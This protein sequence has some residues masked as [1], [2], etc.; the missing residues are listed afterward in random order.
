[1]DLRLPSCCYKTVTFFSTTMHRA[2]RLCGG[3]ARFCK[4]VQLF[5][6]QASNQ[7]FPVETLCNEAFPRMLTEGWA[8]KNIHCHADS[9]FT[10]K[11]VA[12]KDHWA[13]SPK[14]EKEL[15][16]L[17]YFPVLTEATFKRWAEMQL[18]CS[19]N[20]HD[21]TGKLYFLIN[22]TF[23]LMFLVIW[24]NSVAWRFSILLCCP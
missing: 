13:R 14:F 17:N 12:C 23:Q 1:M 24:A 10:H 3:L 11:N 15:I 20:T 19:P 6:L 2:M 16:Y 18:E 22:L 8:G 21:R 5:K 4:H 9:H 7:R